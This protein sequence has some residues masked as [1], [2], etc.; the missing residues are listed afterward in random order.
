MLEFPVFSWKVGLGEADCAFA[1]DMSDC[2]KSRYL[3][4]N[5]GNGV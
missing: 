3:F 2:G 1:N 5:N 4:I